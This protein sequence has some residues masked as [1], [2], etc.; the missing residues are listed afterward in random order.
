MANLIAELKQRNVFKVATI[1]VVVS[2]LILQVVSVVFPVFEIPNWA[3]R[4]VVLLLGLGFPV[5]LVL[6]WAFDLTPEG[7]KWQ[8]K[9]GEHHVH[10]HAWD[11][12]LAV[13]LVVAIGLLVTS[14]IDKWEASKSEQAQTAVARDNNRDI[15]DAF[16]SPGES[17]AQSSIAVLPFDNLSAGS[18]EDYI[19]DGIADE[20]LG[21]LGRVAELKVASRT[22]TAYY[23]NKDIDNAKIAETLQVENVLS[24]SIRSTQG[25][26][27]VTAVLD[28][29]LTGQVLWTETYDRRFEDLL[30]IQIEIA[31]AVAAAIVPVLSPSSRTRIEARPTTSSEAYDYYLRGQD[32]LR[33]PSE[34]STLAGAIGL[35]EKAIEIDPRFAEAHAGRC[36]ANLR[37]YEFSRRAEFFETAEIACHRALT[38]DGSLWDVRVALGNLYNING[39]FDRAIMELEAAIEQQPNAVNAYIILATVYAAQDRLDEAEATFKRA[40]EVESGYW[41]VHRAFGHFYYDQSRYQEA[42]ERYRRVA[43]LAPDHGIGQDN[44]GNTYLAIGELDLAEQAFNASP[45][46]SRW[47]YTNRGL[48]HYYQGNFSEAVADQLKAIALAPDEHRAWGRLGDAYRFMPGREEDALTAYQTAIRYAEQELAINP[49]DSDSLVR[50]SMYY[51]H[52]GDINKA[53]ERLEKVLNLADNGSTYYFATITSLHLGDEEKAWQYLA[54]TLE[55]GFSKKLI[56]N[57]PDFALFSDR[58]EFDALTLPER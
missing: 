24:G 25:R 58:T 21:V 6:A 11:W 31:R 47:L 5:A 36:N 56:R 42:I 12:I 37:N 41:G 46:P 16:G 9:V 1:Y 33:R 13:L 4:L 44:L 28:R 29:A 35:F 10:T 22:S 39:Q 20:L 7:I 18:Q 15:V 50:T 43:E 55:R 53:K 38:L 30:D 34:E 32:Y 23:K 19:G 3:S 27:R 54:Q 48:V 17:Q 14:E 45:L 8:S 57:D 49:S 2:W 26:I 40:E 51:V 52:S